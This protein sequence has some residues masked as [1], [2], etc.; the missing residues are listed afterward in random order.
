MINFVY[1]DLQGWSNFVNCSDLNVSGIRRMTISPVANTVIRLIR[2]EKRYASILETMTVADL[3]PDQGAYIVPTGVAHSPWDWC[4]P[5]RNNSGFV[6]HAPNRKNFFEYISE[7]L[8]KDLRSGR[9]FILIDQTHEGYQS[10]WLWEWFHTNCSH[11]EIDPKQMIY[12]TGNMDAAPQYKIWADEHALVS[13]MLVIGHAHFEHVIY[14]IAKWYNHSKFRLPWMPEPKEVP[15]VEEHINYKEKNLANIKMFNI[16][17]KRPRAHR[18]WFFKHIYE[19]GLIDDNIISMNRFNYKDTYYENREMMEE[20]A[21][22]MNKLLPIVPPE[23]PGTNTGNNFISDVGGDYIQ[24]LNEQ[25]M[26]DTW[27]TVVSE[28]SYGDHDTTCF[29]S[30]KT[31]KPIACHHPFVI[32]GSKGILQNLR[33]M[34]YKTFHPY[35]DESYDDLSTWPRMRAVTNELVRLSKM[36]DQERLQW[37]KNI[38]PI[39]EHNA[40]ILKKRGNTYAEAFVDAVVKHIGE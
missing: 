21:I 24:T 2:T 14:E 27:C 7:S 15:G 34:G 12:M 1:E 22:E 25:T 10:E 33:K 17:Q 13:R 8:L 5:D 23:H 36:S 30:E 39:L 38:S 16:L 40:N 35:I 31:F 19:A 11:Y 28:A 9:A 20:E 3:P 29:I 32:L 4:G 37:F 6:D 18:M 26:L